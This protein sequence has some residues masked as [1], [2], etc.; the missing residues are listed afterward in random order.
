MDLVLKGRGVRITDHFREHAGRKLERLTRLE[1]KAVRLEVEVIS[2]HHPRQDGTK[3]LEGTLAVPRR[4]FRATAEGPDVEV[5]LDRL[6]DR[7][8]RM[9]RDHRK[10]LRDRVMAGASRLKSGRATPDVA[11]GQ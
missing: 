6:V 11:R 10:R 9:V 3:R 5:A 4:T 7:L 1:P 2:E 8:E